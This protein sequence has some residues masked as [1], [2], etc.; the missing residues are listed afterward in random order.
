MLL[1]WAFGIESCGKLCCFFPLLLFHVLL[2]F[3]FFYY[4]WNLRQCKWWKINES[5]LSWRFVTLIGTTS[6]TVKVFFFIRK[7][8]MTVHAFLF[9]WKWD[10][11]MDYAVVKC[12]KLIHSYLLKGFYKVVFVFTPK[13]NSKCVRRS[14]TSN[15]FIPSSCLVLLLS[16][17]WI[18]QNQQ[19]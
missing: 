17:L 3:V 13:Q 8:Q 14:L 15:A 9:Q 11:I 12:W 1:L 6:D 10:E 2:V 18:M 16:G 5:L 4:V 19:F 7:S